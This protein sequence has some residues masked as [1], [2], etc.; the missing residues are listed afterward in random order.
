MR[1]SVSGFPLASR[2]PLMK[3]ITFYDFGCLHPKSS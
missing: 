1:K 2:S 3:S